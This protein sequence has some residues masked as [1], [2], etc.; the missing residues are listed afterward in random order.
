KA[1]DHGEELGIA[2]N[3][4]ALYSRAANEKTNGFGIADFTRRRTPARS[5]FRRAKD[6]LVLVGSSRRKIFFIN[7][8]G[9]VDRK[10]G[11]PN[12]CRASYVDHVQRIIRRVP[13]WVWIFD[14]ITCGQ[15]RARNGWG[16]L[17]Q[18]PTRRRLAQGGPLPHHLRCLDLN[19]SRQIFSGSAS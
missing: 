12:P 9:A 13:R 19:R 3:R 6:R 14:K 16:A 10:N 15:S 17:Y 11:F 7:R 1:L 4:F 5:D 2:L 18:C 8:I